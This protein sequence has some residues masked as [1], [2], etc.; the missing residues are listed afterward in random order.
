MVNIIYLKC[1][2]SLQQTVIRKLDRPAD[3]SS[4]FSRFQ[5]YF[6][7]RELRERHKSSG[8]PWRYHT[9]K[10]PRRISARPLAALVYCCPK[11]RQ[12]SY[13]IAYDGQQTQKSFCYWSVDVGVM[14]A[15]RES[16]L[17]SEG[18]VCKPY[19]GDGGSYCAARGWWACSPLP[20]Q[21]IVTIMCDER[22]PPKKIEKKE[23]KFTLK[24]NEYFFHHNIEVGTW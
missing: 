13:F 12:T 24:L 11:C 15:A 2:Q 9:A 1:N 6:N 5:R 20:P 3:N 10:T 18:D 4:L 14:H 22:A 8:R 21:Y 7:S 16:A 19:V 17:D 23:E